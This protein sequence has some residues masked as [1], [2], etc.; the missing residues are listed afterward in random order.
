MGERSRLR[1]E[2]MKL[3]NWPPTTREMLLHQENSIVVP[4][5]FSPLH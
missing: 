3:P 5:S 2:A 1:A 4:A